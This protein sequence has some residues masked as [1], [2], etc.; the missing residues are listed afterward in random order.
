[1][2][3]DADD[4]DDVDDDVEPYAEPVLDELDELLELADETDSRTPPVPGSLVGFSLWLTSL[5]AAAKAS[6]VLFPVELFADNQHTAST[7]HKSR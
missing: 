4:M 1:M 5:A 7:N 2:M 3:E 6:S